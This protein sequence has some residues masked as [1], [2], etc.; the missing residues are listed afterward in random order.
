MLVGVG[1][2]MRLVGLSST[3]VFTTWTPD[4]GPFPTYEQSRARFAA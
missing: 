1:Y 4:Q 2:T 3:G